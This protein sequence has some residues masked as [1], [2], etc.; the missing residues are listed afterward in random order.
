MHLILTGGGTAGHITP[1]LA[2][3]EELKAAKPNLKITY[4]GSKN[5]YE[6]DLLKDQPVDFKSVPV[7]KLRRYFDLKNFTD[8]FKVPLGILKAS[9]LIRKL[10]PNLVFSKGGYVGL[11]VVIGAWLNKVPIIIHESDSVPGLTTKLT[12]RF[13]SES[14]ASYSIDGFVQVDM[15]IRSFLAKG[16]STKYKHDT[17]PTLLVMGG[18]Q[19]AKGINDFIDFNLELLTEQFQII[20]I[21][22]KGKSLNKT[23]PDYTSYEYV[24]NELAD[25]YAAAD[26][27]LTRSGAGTLSELKALQKKSILVPLPTNRSRGEQLANAKLFAAENPSVVIPQDELSMILFNQAIDELKK[28]DFESNEPEASA[29]NRILAWMLKHSN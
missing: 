19:G 9:Y 1:N 23:A 16:D 4:I 29:T 7:G 15:P 28:R 13:A 25:I 12:K 11:P 10:K 27:V 24:S 3:I 14:W 5:G 8:I 18:S 20:H 17:K 21:T 22:G 6:K 26:F 2:L